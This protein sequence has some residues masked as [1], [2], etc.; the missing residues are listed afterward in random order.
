MTASGADTA[1]VFSFAFKNLKGRDGTNGT[2]GTNGVP[3]THSWSGTTLSITSASGTSSADLKGNPGA[4]AGFGTP[5]ATVDSNSGTPSVTVTT[6]GPDTAKV[7]NFAFKN[8]KGKDGTNGTNGTNGVTPTIKAANGANVAS[9]GT[10][11]VTAS[12]S[13]TTTT[14][15]FNY[16]KGEKGDPG[17]TGATGPQ[18]PPGPVNI[19]ST[20]TEGDTSAISSG[21]VYDLGIQLM[22]SI[23]TRQPLITQS[24]DGGFEIKNS[25]GNVTSTMYPP[26][27]AGTAGQI[28][29]S[30]GSG[31]GAWRTLVTIST[32]EPSGGSDGDLWFQYEE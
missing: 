26:T 25:L 16:L 6:S 20:P 4:A 31:P 30:D 3:C 9:I 19:V 22:E 2:N 29:V 7:F 28:W 11:S 5:T 15:T 27:T 21:G 18:G 12:T 1:K 14:F 24:S 13:G 8:L 32:A 17:A 10:P 23:F